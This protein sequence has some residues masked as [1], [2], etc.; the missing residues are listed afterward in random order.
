MLPAGAVAAAACLQLVTAMEHEIEKGLTGD[1]RRRANDTVHGFVSQFWHTVHAWLELSPGD[2]LFV[3]G[4]EDFDV[5]SAQAATAT[6]V[7]ATSSKITLRSSDVINTIKNFWD[8][9]RKNADR[10]IYYRFLTTSEKTQE[11]G[12]PFGPG[13]CGL[14]VWEHSIRDPSLVESLRSFFVTEKC[15]EGDLKDFIDCTRS[16]KPKANRVR[17]DTPSAYIARRASCIQFTAGNCRRGRV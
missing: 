16:G 1:S 6:Q 5:I 11:K 17:C 12:A 10:S 7:K 2:L 13:V 4:A 3:E 15:F 9:R 14:D 8:T